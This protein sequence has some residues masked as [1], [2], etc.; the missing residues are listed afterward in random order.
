MH[1]FRDA[2][3]VGS[4]EEALI[5][6]P[7]RRRGTAAAL[8]PIDAEASPQA[9]RKTSGTAERVGQEPAGSAAPLQGGAQRQRRIDAGGGSAT[10][11]VTR[12]RGW[13]T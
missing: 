9:L 12:P 11:S 8:L 7:D 10:V 5:L 1:V 6:G 4:H 13:S 3:S 2:A